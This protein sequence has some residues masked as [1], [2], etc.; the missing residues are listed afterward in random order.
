MK[1]TRRIH[2]ES[3]IQGQS[4]QE[5]RSRIPHRLA[6]LTRNSLERFRSRWPNDLWTIDS[7]ESGESKQTRSTRQT[8]HFAAVSIAIW[9]WPM[10]MTRVAGDSLRLSF[11]K[12]A[13]SSFISAIIGTRRISLFLVP[14]S[15]SPRTMISS[16]VTAW[17]RGASGRTR[18]CN[19][20][21][22]SQKLYPIELPTHSHFSRS[23]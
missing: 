8:G 22:R 3:P 19:L 15:G 23:V 7:D 12:R 11:R 18:T 17:Y 10:R 1:L 21:I 4:R 14:S 13:N 9:H 6:R 16:V 5:F 20:L 2:P